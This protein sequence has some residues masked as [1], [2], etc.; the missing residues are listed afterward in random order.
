MGAR[1]ADV[2][3]GHGRGV[4]AAGDHLPR[5]AGATH[6]HVA[7]IAALD[8]PCRQ[9]DQVG[10]GRSSR[11]LDVGEDFWTVDLFL[12]ELDALVGEFGLDAY[13]VIG[14]SWGGM[15]A[16]EHA[17]RQRPGLRSIVVAD[18][19]ASIPLWVAEAS[20]GLAV[21]A[22]RGVQPHVARRGARAFPRRRRRLPGRG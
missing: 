14:Q 17:L 19:P 3:R 13:H 21:G 22:V 7:S 5:R 16:M 9:Y 10:N 20:G 6:D 4:G 8:R 18:S 1:A 2:V 12:R 11:G 15:L